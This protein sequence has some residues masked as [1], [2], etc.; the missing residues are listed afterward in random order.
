[1]ALLESQ[2]T[3]RGLESEISRLKDTFSIR[4]ETIMKD[5]F[6]YDRAEDGGPSGAAY[7]SRCELKDAFLIKLVRSPGH[8][9]L[10]CPQCKT[11]Y[12]RATIYGRGG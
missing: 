3:A 1:M 7:C 4:A 9:G 8:Q 5:D 2:D 10:A 12:G 6:R 11:A